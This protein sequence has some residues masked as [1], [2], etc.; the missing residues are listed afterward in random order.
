M[1]PIRAGWKFKIAFRNHWKQHHFIVI[2]YE[3]SI[4][5]QYELIILN[6]GIC[7]E[8]GKHQWYGLE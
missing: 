7:I 5:F 1:Q 2:G 6:L 8:F 3:W 4:Y